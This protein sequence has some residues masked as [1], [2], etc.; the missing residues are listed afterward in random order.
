MLSSTIENLFRRESGRLISVLTRLLGPQNLQ[1]AE[2]VLQDAFIAAMRDW[3]ENGIP[4]NPPAWLLTAARRRAIDAIRR[5]RTRR[6]FA[7]DLAKFLDSEWTLA[8]TVDDAF[9]DQWARD[10]QLRM[11]FMCCH[12]TL[13]PESQ[14]TVILKTMCGLSVPAIARAL[15]TSEAT[16]NKRLYRARQALREVRFE[17]PAPADM[18]GARDIV[19]T[20]LYL[21]FNEGYLSTADTPIIR[22]LCRDAMLMTQLLAEDPAIASSDTMALLS[23][24]CFNA[25]RLESR[26][27]PNG[28]L[29]PLDE[30]D[31]A[32]WDRGLIGRGFG[33]LALSSEMDAVAATR[34]H[35]EAAIAAR[36]SEA[37]SFDE[38]DWE[39]I[40]RLYDRLMEVEQSPMI[41]LNR[42]VAVSFRDGPL[43][44]VPLVESIRDR[45]GLD[46]SHVV[47][48]VF[49]NLYARAGSMDRA[50]GFLEA[51]LKQARSAHERDLIER[52][53]ARASRG[54]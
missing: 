25:A 21:L 41:E 20:A 16:I 26:L 9:G 35:L 45:G 30:Q 18:P 5:E 4:D 36:H 2:D 33:Y 3:S 28:H 43:S 14:V 27:D 15:L 12:Q 42:A 17:L 1:L 51:A 24:M 23:L 32:R 44:A 7:A 29:I 47:A 19:H 37:A 40:C 46:G 34:Y 53:I 31:R 48:A 10:D 54:D 13:S 52:Q 22:E 38:T 11:I 39:S 50:R 8:L 6:T 49:A